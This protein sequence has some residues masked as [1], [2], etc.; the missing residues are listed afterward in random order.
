MKNLRAALVIL[1]LLLQPLSGWAA[2]AIGGAPGIPPMAG[3]ACCITPGLATNSSSGQMSAMDMHHACPQ[4]ANMLTGNAPAGHSDM[5]CSTDQQ[6]NCHCNIA[7]GVALA[8]PS[9]QP[10]LLLAPPRSAHRPQ[11]DAHLFNSAPL[12]ALFRPPRT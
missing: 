11:F 3:M 2:L 7:C 1:L 4:Q 10:Q 12:D 6:G 9:A 5:P 8:T